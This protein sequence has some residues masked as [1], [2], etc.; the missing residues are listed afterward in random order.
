LTGGTDSG[1]HTPS[2]I[3]TLPDFKHY[4]HLVK[5]ANFIPDFR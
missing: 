3:F 5:S 1:L 2:I 4:E